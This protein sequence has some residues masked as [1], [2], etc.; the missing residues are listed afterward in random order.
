MKYCFIKLINT[1]L[2]SGT[3]VIPRGRHVYPFSCHLPYDIP[4]T[5]NGPHGSI[6][7]KIKAIVD[8]PMRVDHEDE[9]IF[10]L[11]SPIDFN[12]MSRDLQ[13]FNLL[14]NFFRFLCFFFLGY[15]NV[16]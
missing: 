9:F 4:S 6:S 10:V 7:Y 11:V 1:F 13:V 14:I 15:N 5:F 16:L 3:R 8:R 12:K 2:A